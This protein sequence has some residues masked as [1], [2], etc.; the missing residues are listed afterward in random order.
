MGAGAPDCWRQHGLA[1]DAWW[2]NR[3]GGK[4]AFAVNRQLL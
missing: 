4:R 3:T 1:L 2:Q